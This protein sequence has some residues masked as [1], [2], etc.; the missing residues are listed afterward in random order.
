M[1]YLDTS[2]ILKCYLTEHGSREVRD[3]TQSAD[4]LASCYL[5]RVE[6]AA[7]VHRQRREGT[8]SEAGAKA[9]FDCFEADEQ[10]G[11]WR[12]HGVTQN[13]LDG[14]F[15]TY[16][17]LAPALFVRTNDA[18]HLACAREQGF[19]EIYTNDRHLLAAAPAFSL[20]GIDVI[21]SQ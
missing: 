15:S 21:P 1:I 19:K 18:V 10:A 20:D 14:V 16:Q 12:W 2:Y 5:A 4:G 8:L 7:A 11:Y 9:V 17:S 13:L 3:L 6:F